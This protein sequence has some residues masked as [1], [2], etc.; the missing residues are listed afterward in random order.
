[1]K[2]FISI[3]LSVTVS[4]CGY[5]DN[6]KF[7]GEWMME[8]EEG[9]V[10][11]IQIN[12]DLK[13]VIYGTGGMHIPLVI[14]EISKERL[15]IEFGNN[16]DEEKQKEVGFK[17]LTKIEP[18]QNIYTYK[19]DEGKL[20]LKEVKSGEKFVWSNCKEGGCN[21]EKFYYLKLGLS[22]VKLSIPEIHNGEIKSEKINGKEIRLF[23]G[24]PS[25]IWGGA[26]RNEYQV[27]AG[28]NFL[29][30][31][32]IVLAVEKQARYDTETEWRT[33][34]LFVDKSAPMQKLYELKRI[35]DMHYKV[36]KI[37]AQF[38]LKQKM[39]KGDGFEFLKIEKAIDLSKEEETKVLFGEWINEE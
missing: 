32:H 18:A 22:G 15:T 28:K 11:M 26:F 10:S 17:L 25:E 39:V 21:G 1:M 9:A 30:D 7:S 2:L 24:K 13:G 8:N 12:S 6:K 33:V 36:L 3:I 19:F 27:S 14:K 4:T 16:N 35:F 34:L 31:I 5:N 20:F 29:K 23:I 37:K 38:A